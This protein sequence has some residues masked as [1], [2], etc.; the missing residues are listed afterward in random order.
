M[1]TKGF[2]GDIEANKISFRY[3]SRKENVFTKLSVKVR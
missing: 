3:E 1:L 2:E